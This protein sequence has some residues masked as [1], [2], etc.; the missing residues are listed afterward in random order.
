[1]AILQFRV[2]AETVGPYRPFQSLRSR[3]AAALGIIL[4]VGKPPVFL[5]FLWSSRK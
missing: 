5:D 1:M 3:H 2:A 4:P